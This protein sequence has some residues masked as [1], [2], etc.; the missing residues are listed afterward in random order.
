[1]QKAVADPIDTAPHV[2]ILPAS[3]TGTTMTGAVFPVLIALSFCHLLNDM[4]QS[5]ITAL[6]PMLKE[7]FSLNFGQIGLISLAFQLTASLLQPAV[8]MMTDR[9]PMPFSL[10]VGMGFTLV[11][12]LMLSVAG[13]YPALLTAAAMVGIGS[14]VFHPESSRVARAASGG[15]YGL[16]QSLFQVGGN[17]GSAV[18]PLLAA[19]VVLTRGQSS[20][21]WFSL[22][23]LV[24]ML[25]LARVGAWYKANMGRAASKGR[26]RG[27]GGVVLSRQRVAWA[28]FILA[29]LTFSKNVYTASLSSY[30]TFYLIDRFHMSVHD[31]QMH[32]FIFMAAVAVGTLIGGPIGDRIGRKPTIWISIVGVLPFTLMLPYA[33]LFFT[34]V[35]TIIIGLLMASAFPAILVYAQEL[36]PGRVGMIAGIF[37]GFAFGLGGLGAAAMGRIADATSISFV[38]QIASFLPAIGLLTA[39]LPNLAPAQRAVAPKPVAR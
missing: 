28:I 9:R 39:L 4:M 26:A 14:S 6:Y 17:A 15:R 11:G 35:L 29:A 16:A 23:A 18:G 20:V 38:Y 8:G 13:S 31:A 36:V 34:D 10:A 25:I 12:L 21:A 32:L 3:V 27:A 2:Q 22:A 7:Q 33:N 19:V 37:F 30:F 24:G 5:M 1:M